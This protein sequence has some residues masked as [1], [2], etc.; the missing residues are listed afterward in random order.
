MKKQ[1]SESL[2]LKVMGKVLDTIKLVTLGIRTQIPEN[3]L[4]RQQISEIPKAIYI[5]QYI[6]ELLKRKK[7]EESIDLQRAGLK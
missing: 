1:S 4:K 2:L 3:L 6:H 5:Y 7:T